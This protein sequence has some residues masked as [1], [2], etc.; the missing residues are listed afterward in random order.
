MADASTVDRF[1]DDFGAERMWGLRELALPDSVGLFPETIGWLYLS[2]F[3][4]V[5]LSIYAWRRYQRWLA[6][7][8]LRDAQLRLKNM[9]HDP[10]ALKELPSILRA[11]ALHIA[12]RSEV[13]ALRGQPW[14]D[15][16]NKRVDMQLFQEED[17]TLLNQLAYSDCS[18]IDS[19][20][21]Q[22]LINNCDL[23]LRASHV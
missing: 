7:G 21:S 14:I 13:A 2:L 9:R 15:W 20:V 4:L 6:L 11:T 3:V 16:L 19:S 17:A 1:G 10:A 8:Y 18:N 22:Q 23:W 12:P 5:L